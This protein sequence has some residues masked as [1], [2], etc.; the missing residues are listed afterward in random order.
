M[1]Q[2]SNKYILTEVVNILDLLNNEKMESRWLLLSFV[3]Y[4]MWLPLSFCLT[5]FQHFQYPK[6]LCLIKLQI[7]E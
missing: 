2:E 1:S 7:P 5:G 6:C 3:T 4:N